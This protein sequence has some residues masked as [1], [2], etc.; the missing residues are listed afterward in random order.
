M[1]KK[2]TEFGMFVK[3]EKKKNDLNNLFKI[4]FS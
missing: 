2:K 4:R 1:W 3:L